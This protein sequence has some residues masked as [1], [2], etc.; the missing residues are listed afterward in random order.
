MGAWK[1][2][3][4]YSFY[5]GFSYWDKDEGADWA[6]YVYHEDGKMDEVK[7]DNP[8]HY[9]YLLSQDTLYWESLSETG[10]GW[11]RVLELS[12][13]KM[14]LRKE[15]APM[16]GDEKEERYEIRFFSKVKD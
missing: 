3:S 10:G 12:P 8:R 15:K 6:T 5:N 1:V 13:Q 4:V 7:F 2:D 14:V 16:F 11:F 9:R